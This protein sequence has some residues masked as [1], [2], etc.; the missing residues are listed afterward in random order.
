MIAGVVTL[1]TYGLLIAPINVLTYTVKT[2]E[3]V[4]PPHNFYCSITLHTLT[5]IPDSFSMDQLNEALENAPA[6]AEYN[7]NENLS[8]DE[9]WDLAHEE[10][11]RTGKLSNN[12]PVLHKAMMMQMLMK[13][14]AF[15]EG[16]SD[17]MRE[18]SAPDDVVSAWLKDA[19]K[20]QACMNILTTISVDNDD[21][22]VEEAS[23]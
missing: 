21:F 22:M 15:H 13:M 8:Q 20:F 2:H 4:P 3:V 12:G 9:I 23:K 11:K 7:L 16:M 14:I 17:S 5:A 6:E 18:Q 1:E 10:V 19:G